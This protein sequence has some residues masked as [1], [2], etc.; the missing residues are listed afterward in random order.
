MA[1]LSDK[2]ACSDCNCKADDAFTK[3]SKSYCSKAC[4]TG[5]IDGEGCC[6]NSCNC[7]G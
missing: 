7:H 4:A 6:N 3:E 2:C 5:H 1:L